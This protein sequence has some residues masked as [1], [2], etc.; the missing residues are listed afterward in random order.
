MFGAIGTVLAGT[1]ATSA[2]IAVPAGVTSGQIILVHL[3]REGTATITAPSGFTEITPRQATTTRIVEHS[4][5]WKRA[6]GADSG[7]YTFTWTGNIWRSGVAIR[8]TDCV[9]SGSPVDVHNGAARSSSGTVTPAVSVTTTGIDRLLVWSGMCFNDGTWTMPSG[10]TGR[11][12]GNQVLGVG[13]KSQAAAGSSGSLTGSNT[14][15][16][17]QTARVVALLPV[18]SASAPTVGAGVDVAAHPVDTQFA[19]T[20]TENDNGATITARA[21]TIQSG[22]AGVGSTVGT[23][24]A[25]SWTPTTAGTYV[26]RYSATNSAGTG[27]DDVTVTVVGPLIWSGL[28][29][30]NNLGDE[31]YTDNPGDRDTPNEVVIVTDRVRGGTRSARVTVNGPGVNNGNQR[32][33]IVPLTATFTEGQERWFG[34]SV[35]LDA[36]FPINPA[37]WQLISQWHQQSGTGSPPVE[38]NVDNGEFALTGENAA[39]TAMGRQVI[40]AATRGQWHDFQIR[41]L[42]SATPSTAQIEVWLNGA[43]A[44]ATFSSPIGTIYSGPSEYDYWKSGIYRNP[45]Q[46]DTPLTLWL[47]E[48]R[49][50]T[51]RAAVTPQ[52]QAVA[53]S[54]TGAG[55]L[56]VVTT[57]TAVAATTFAG[58]GALS[59]TGVTVK[60]GATTFA[61][62]GQMTMAGVRIHP[63]AA[64]F[65][66]SGQMAATPGQAGSA[67]FAG[68]GQLT[69]DTRQTH[70]VAAT[71]AGAGQMLGTGY[72]TRQAA[73][74]LAGAG[75]MT[76][77]AARVHP[78]AATF[79]GAGALTAD[80]RRV[81]PAQAT[82]TG[83]GNFAATGIRIRSAATTFTGAGRL[84]ASARVDKAGVNLPL[85]AVLSS[86]VLAP[87]PA[88]QTLEL[89]R[90][91]NSVGSVRV[92]YPV[93]GTG[94]GY[95]RAAVDQDRPV[96]VEMWL[97]GSADG[98]LRALLTQSAGDDLDGASVWT[99]TGT[100]LEAVLA[101][102]IVH[103]QPLP[104]EKGELRFDAKNA[105]QV[106]LTVLQQAQ[107]RGALTGIMRDWTTS[108]DSSGQAWPVTVSGL[109]YS[110][111]ANLLEILQDLADKDLCEFEVTAGRVLRLWAPDR[112]GVDRTGGAEP[113]LFRWGR[114]SS[115]PLRHSTSDVAT[116][117]LAIGKDGLSA[118]ASDASA[119]ARIGRRVEVGVDAGNIDNQAALTAYAQAALAA[120]T[121]GQEEIRHPLTF[122]PGD[123]RPKAG[124]DLADKVLSER[125]GGV[126]RAVDV[127]QWTL[128]ASRQRVTDGEVVLNDLIASRLQRLARQVDRIGSGGAVIG[129]SQP[130]DA[131]PDT[132][133]PAAPTGLVG[134][135][136]AYQDTVDSQ[137]Y[138]SVIIG[139]APVTT[140]ADGSATDDVAGYRVRYAGL[141]LE[142]VGPVYESDPGPAL[143]YREVTP[144]AGVAGTSFQFGGVGAGIPIQLQVQAFDQAGNHSTWSAPLQFT[145]EVDNT[146]PEKP[147]APGQRIWFRTL[148]TSWNGLDFAGAV[149][150]A[151]TDH[152][153]VLMS[154]AASFSAPTLG[155]PVVFNPA[156]T[157]VQH[158]ANL[159][160]AGTWNQP[161]LPIG[162]G[163]YSALVAVDRAGNPSVMSAITG[164]ATA[165]KLVQIDLGPNAVG[166][167]QIIDLEVIRAKID[168]AAINSLKVEEIQV[169][170]LTTGTM[171]ATV[172]NSG[173]FRTA[174]SG[175]R[176]EFDNTGLRLYQGPTIVGRWLTTDAS[177][178]MT[179][180][181]QTA[182]TG[183]RW[184]L[185]PD[186]TQRLYPA[187][188]SNYSNIENFNG[189]AVW[190]GLMD[191][192][193]RSGRLNVGMAG[194][195]MNFSNAGEVPN[196]LRSEV[197]VFDR[198]VRATAPLI[199][200]RVDGRYSPVA[201]G[202]RRLYLTHSNS[203]NVDIGD[204][205]IEYKVT[206]SG[207]EAWM[208]ATGQ[209][210]GI[211]FADNNIYISHNDG[212]PAELRCGNLIELSAR[213]FKDRIRD[214][215]WT[216]AGETVTA[217]DVVR[218][219]RSQE[220][221]YLHDRARAARPGL[222]LRRPKLSPVGE[223]VVDDTGVA[224]FDEVPA[225]WNFDLPPAPKRYG[226]MADDLKVLAPSLVQ[227]DPVHPDREWVSVS[228]K[229]GVVWAAVGILAD[230]LETLVARLDRLDGGP[231][232]PVQGRP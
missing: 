163:W 91:R 29:E 90:E 226:P 26:L 215:A 128:T 101:D 228:D 34:F 79:A 141:G 155:E 200:L 180:T 46:T 171:T 169:G 66:G 145:T 154:Q 36:A 28:F 151:D 172:T 102:G 31:F 115:S 122:G 22:P 18:A 184:V 212:N 74:A 100:F 187:S 146:A 217:L 177:M 131:E 19:R 194:V 232:T 25:L 125:R 110:P 121:K 192:N 196:N 223:P 58:A 157:G 189:E 132:L 3:Y 92:A 149:M 111:K 231:R 14:D 173:L 32:A 167:A 94:F 62:S 214:I 27:T 64:T 142:Q 109:I 164:P 207:N 93:A 136:I 54:F 118:T 39:G 203:S 23:A 209:N 70:L 44:L 97:G 158:V 178:L 216:R 174:S 119:E 45:T 134:E 162:V 9:A 7:T 210:S 13:D 190:R 112:R 76:V 88:F 206:G 208:Q 218:G 16:D 220:F 77:A 83:A 165:A 96:E 133:A 6:T 166:S 161:D 202:T 204:S 84:T 86:G 42:F 12:P 221:E 65:T 30:S 176:V 63:A 181:F 24:A 152:V 50:G 219:A 199:G 105:G 139:W 117:V 116:A 99:F 211:I 37:S 1:E 49:V 33:E 75:Q 224:V 21:W 69:V 59:T 148:D 20:A 113:T 4:I 201:G 71:F 47:D 153:A 193:G 143:A 160:G 225:E 78:N 51:T 107:T 138:A 103:P 87:L 197:V 95:L 182:L 57:K 72:A 168:N 52:V 38:L 144:A 89:S 195:G 73:V 213:R 185:L 85:W 67:S 229:V 40:A 188:G 8:Y 98:T 35:W 159:Y 120:L 55:A 150:A 43:Q 135:S 108:L 10:F 179:G 183:E 137:T 106:V 130:P 53:A 41:I 56:T 205:V 82:F 68:A 156:T 48:M 140:N 198:F 15:A 81:H 114:V 2:A 104:A 230:R 227:A 191:A 17:Y 175:N 80:A 123:P 126:R 127:Q 60:P 11:G 147:S 170:L 124:Y 186:G 222:N 61:G 5:W 129:T